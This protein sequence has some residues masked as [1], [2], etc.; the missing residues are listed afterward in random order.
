MYFKLTMITWNK[1]L[2]LLRWWSRERTD[3]LQTQHRVFHAFRTAEQNPERVSHLHNFQNHGWHQSQPTL[4]I[5]SSFS[6]WLDPFWTTGVSQTSPSMHGPT[7]LRASQCRAPGS[8]VISTAIGGPKS[9]HLRK[10]LGWGIPQII[11]NIHP[12]NFEIDGKNDGFGKCI[13]ILSNK[14]I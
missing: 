4:L 9:F 12:R 8:N 10:S 7:I 13:S 2:N 11:Y 6:G 5:V 3:V 1:L 14:V